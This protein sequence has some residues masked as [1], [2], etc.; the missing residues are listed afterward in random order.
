MGK[1]KPAPSFAITPGKKN[2]KV[3][4]NLFT[5]SDDEKN[6]A[7]KGRNQLYKNL[8]FL[9]NACT[10]KCKGETH[11]RSGRFQPQPEQFLL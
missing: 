2:R 1:K 5:L 9:N 4:N 10:I 11:R 6:R 3:M 8:I 7:I